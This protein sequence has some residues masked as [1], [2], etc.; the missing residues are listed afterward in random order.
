M[1]NKISVLIAD[2]NVQFGDMLQEFI[3]SNDDMQVVGV[4]RDGVQAIEMIKDYNPDIVI[5]DII[6][7]NLDGIGVLEK[8]SSLDLSKKPA[9]IMLSAL[10]QDAF[11]QNAMALGAGYYIVKPFDLD[12]MVTRIREMYRQKDFSLFTQFRQTN[13]DQSSGAQVS[14][15]QNSNDKNDKGVPTRRDIGHDIETVVTELMRSV[16][17]PPHMMG[18]Q[19]IREAVIQIVNSP[20][21]FNS[22]TKVLYPA[23]AKKYNSTPQRVERA[24]RN[25]IDSAWS[26]ASPEQIESTF[27]HRNKPTNS[28]FIAMIAD[29]TRLSLGIKI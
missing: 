23:V 9:V 6:M 8:L 11:I 26:K 14:S 4:A 13:K 7:P 10:G 29:K 2:D 3:N 28:E 16:G 18:Y 25:A 17:I 1:S 27:G 20:S 22:M 15:I 12:V 5:L 24:I 19:Y 21:V